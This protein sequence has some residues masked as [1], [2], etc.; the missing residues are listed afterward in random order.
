MLWVVALGLLGTLWR[1]DARVLSK[2][3]AE[4]LHTVHKRFSVCYDDLGCYSTGS[5]FWSIHR[6]INFLPQTPQKINTRFFLYTRSNKAHYSQLI[7][8]HYSSITNSHFDRSKDTKIISHGFLENGFVAW[9]RNMKDEFLKSEDL[10]V[11]LVDWGGGSAFPYT[12]ATANTQVVGAEIA[13]LISVLK[14]IS[15]ADPTK[16]HII[17]HSLGAHI[18]GYAGERTPNLGR[19]TGLDPAGPYFE[20][21]DKVVRL[22]PTDAIFVDA[23]HTDAESL[24]PNI[25][26]G[27]MEP[28]GHVDFYPNGG[29]D[30][31]G[32]NT[33]PLTHIQ[34]QGGIY[35][36]TKQFIACNHLRAYEY[37]TESINSVCP[38]EAYSCDSYDH[39][40]DGTCHLDCSVA[41]NCGKMG[42][43][44]GELKS[45]KSAVGKKYF[46]KTTTR[47]PYCEYHY[48]IRVTLGHPSGSHE[49]R[50]ELK[51]NIHGTNG[52]LG[53]RTV[54]ED[55]VYFQPGK[56]YSYVIAIPHSIGDI[57]DVS[58]QWAH[59]GLSVNPFQWNL[60]NLRHPKL[61]FER[62][63]VVSGGTHQKVAF[64][65]TVG[66]E[67]GTQ[68]IINTK[69]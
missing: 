34:I 56:S 17:G 10:N 63:E 13:K 27:M 53:Q 46:L 15:N 54:T 22:D 20:N 37:F 39:F 59:H 11:I 64:C 19:I 1:V 2:D 25:G 61:Y 66:T 50:G 52:Q 60:F 62:V 65:S 69:C 12:Q 68:R 35:D 45:V 67:S 48:V 55:Y 38:F 24:V 6:P 5:P 33:D 9:M 32:C 41:G 14:K 23:L 44:A 57:K 29:K 58:L 31:P 3:Q 42:Y 26:F 49:W 7:A 21:T 16:I 18:A 8:N 28:V 30:Q 47:D 4:T 51:A 43:H 36:G 40:K